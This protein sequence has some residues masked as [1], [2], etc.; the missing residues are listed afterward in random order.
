MMSVV[1]DYLSRSFQTE[2]SVR[3]CDDDSSTSEADGCRYRLRLEEELPVHEP[4]EARVGRDDFVVQVYQF[5]HNTPSDKKKQGAG[6][7]L[8]NPKN[9]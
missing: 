7:W 8:N 6:F 1:R 2:A 9:R 4:E 3:T 5:I